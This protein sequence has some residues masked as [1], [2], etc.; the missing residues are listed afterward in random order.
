MRAE[1]VLREETITSI[2][3]DFQSEIFITL[4]T[5]ESEIQNCNSLQT[6]QKCK[7]IGQNQYFIEIDC[8]IQIQFV[9]RTKYVSQMRNQ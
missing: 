7:H 2:A 6:I 4:E 3:W 9:M 8:L 5:I 1:W